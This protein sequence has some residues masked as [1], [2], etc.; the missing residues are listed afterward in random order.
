MGKSAPSGDL[1]G[2]MKGHPRKPDKGGRNTRG[3]LHF[4]EGVCDKRKKGG[5]GVKGGKP[6]IKG[7]RAEIDS[8]RTQMEAKGERGEAGSMQK[9]EMKERKGG[10]TG[11]LSERK[12]AAK[13][14]VGNSAGGRNTRPGAGGQTSSQ[15]QCS[16][17]LGTTH[18]RKGLA[19]GDRRSSSTQKN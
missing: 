12:V 2:C 5:T 10:G 3:I 4:R 18:Q 15:N 11:L 7:G 13:E 1:P 9:R 14:Q 6:S 17:T 16:G 19:K 8:S